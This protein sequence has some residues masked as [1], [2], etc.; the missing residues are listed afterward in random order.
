MTKH[1]IL[2]AP[3]ENPPT[4]IDD[5][6]RPRVTDKYNAWVQTDPTN[7]VLAGTTGMEGM[8]RGMKIALEDATKAAGYEPTDVRS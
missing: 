1:I 5:S 4:P 2:L 3:C 6:R 7:T 8:S